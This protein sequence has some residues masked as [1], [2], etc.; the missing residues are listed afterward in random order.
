ML[1]WPINLS[2]ELAGRNSSSN[3]EFR[4]SAHAMV[5]PAKAPPRRT[6]AID[7]TQS[8]QRGVSGPSSWRSWARDECRGAAATDESPRPTTRAMPRTAGRRLARPPAERVLR[9]FEMLSYQS[10]AGWKSKD[11]EG[12]DG[13]DDGS[14]RL[15]LATLWCARTKGRRGARGWEFRWRWCGGAAASCYA[16]RDDQGRL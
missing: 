5:R 11:A 13:D 9:I 6:R 3:A 14:Q 10:I 7:A 16:D 1:S 8:T 2:R 15:D 4:M 12:R